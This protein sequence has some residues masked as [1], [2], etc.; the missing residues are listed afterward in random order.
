MNIL[1]GFN[2]FGNYK[3]QSIAVDSYKHLAK[4]FPNDV[5]ILNVQ[6]EDERETFEN[7]Y[8]VPVVHALKTSSKDVISGGTKKLPFVND[9][10]SVA[11]EHASDY[12]IFTNSDV[13]INPNLITYIKQNT[14]DCMACSRLDITD[15]SSFE[16][17]REQAAPVRWE[18]G[19]FDTF[20]FKKSWYLKYAHLF[21][22]YLLGKPYFDHVYAGI[23]QCY[24]DGT[25]LGN[26]YPPFCFH[27][28]H[29]SASVLT[30]SPERDYNMQTYDC[31]P[32]DVFMSKVIHFNL[33][34]NLMKRTPFGAFI[35]PTPNEERF[36]KVVFDNFNIH[37][38]NKNDIKNSF[39]FMFK[40]Q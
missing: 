30:D 34:H 16:A 14:P 10:I 4:I 17:L 11:S 20:V 3:R 22:P 28:H 24:G 38:P 2:T 37:K 15:I 31:H 13:I 9:I 23:M 19:G 5:S 33:Q 25:P 39:D 8:N 27:I 32:E 35:H 1:I 6:F 12:F 7:Y 18:I 40:P 29:G 36:A 21:N 26:G